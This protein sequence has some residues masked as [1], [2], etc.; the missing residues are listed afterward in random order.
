L[1]SATGAVNIADG[2]MLTA[3]PLLAA[4]LS[5]RPTEVAGVTVALHLPWLLF[6]LVSGLLL[7][8]YDRRLLLAVANMI[9][10]A[11]LGALAAVVALGAETL[12][13]LYSAAFAYGMCQ[14]LVDT[15]VQTLTPR[16]VA[17]PHLEAANGRLMAVEMVLNRLVGPAVGGIIF[18][19][20]AGLP[21]ALGAGA[22]T[23]A[24]LLISLLGA[25][26]GAIAEGGR[27]ERWWRDILEGWRFLIANSLLRALTMTVAGVNLLFS[28]GQA[29][30]V[31]LATERLGLSSA[32]FGLLLA[33]GAVGGFLGS[34]AAS[35]LKARLSG[36]RSLAARS[37]SPGRPP[38]SWP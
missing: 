19:V 29:V 13:F 7:D 26:A 25:Q 30:L 33:A 23:L 22:L 11:A 6:G 38:R 34:L 9:R 14:T 36:G 27:S 12:V 21:I 1:W 20:W 24:A 4:G 17:A 35:P 3:F 10:A 37:S 32:G 8:R 18:A 2:L 15:G 31:L 5:E 16:I 28:A